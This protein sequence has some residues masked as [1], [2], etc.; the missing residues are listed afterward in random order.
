MPY[1]SQRP[2]NPWVIVSTKYVIREEAA[3]TDNTNYR[4][5][6]ESCDSEQ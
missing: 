1:E 2:A 6:N 5:R 3:P 4:V